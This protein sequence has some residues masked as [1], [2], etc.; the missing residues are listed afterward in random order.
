LRIW[1]LVP[2]IAAL[3][4]VPVSSATAPSSYLTNALA[5]SGAQK[6]TIASFTGVAITYNNTE[7][8][9]LFVFVYLDLENSAGQ[10][11][12]VWPVSGNISSHGTVTFFIPIS[13]PAS[14]NYSAT[15]FATTS[16][17]VPVSSSVTITVALP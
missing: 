8:S 10:T 1:L 12:Y 9:P 7:S 3:L 6:T 15:L 4:I 11:V 5:P 16:S 2:L 13:G 14:G 17:G